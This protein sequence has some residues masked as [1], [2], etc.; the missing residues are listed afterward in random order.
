MRE[1]NSCELKD[2]SGAGFI[3]DAGAALG[4]G[5]GFVI[6]AAGGKGGK[7]AGA[8]LGGGIGQVVEAGLGFLGSLIGGIFGKRR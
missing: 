8:A 6:E 3:A 5:I 2:V 4:L 1:L 7:E